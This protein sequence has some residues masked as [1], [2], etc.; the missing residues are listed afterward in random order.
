MTSRGPLHAT[1]PE[2][3]RWNRGIVDLRLILVDFVDIDYA[4]LG[5]LDVRSADCNSFIMM[6]STS[7]PT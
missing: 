3:S 1:S 5:A 7:S 4:A 6:F 2:T